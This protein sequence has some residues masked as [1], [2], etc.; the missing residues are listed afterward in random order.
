MKFVERFRQLGTIG[1]QTCEG[2]HESPFTLGRD[3]QK[4]DAT[5]FVR[6]ASFEQPRLLCSLHQLGYRCLFHLH[7]VTELG[8]SDPGRRRRA[9]HQQ[10]VVARRSQACRSRNVIRAREKPSQP[11]S[12]RG[13]TSQLTLDIA[14]LAL[15]G[16]RHVGRCLAHA[17]PDHEAAPLTNT[18]R[19]DLVS[20]TVGNRVA[21]TGSTGPGSGG[22]RREGLCGTSSPSRPCQSRV[23]PPPAW[24]TRPRA[25]TRLVSVCRA[26][27][28]PVPRAEGLYIMA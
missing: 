5:V 12:E 4:P 14:S 22:R 24:R 6:G 18:S 7:E 20:T 2:M 25:R 26:G 1:T 16:S 10:E 15:P 27:R 28:Q 19:Y 3:P 17:S 9:D 13:R 23:R 8:Y 21:G 11:R